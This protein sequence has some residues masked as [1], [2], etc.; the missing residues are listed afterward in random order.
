MK[1]FL[2][3]TA[4]LFSRGVLAQ[5]ADQWGS[6]PNRPLTLEDLIPPDGRRFSLVHDFKYIDLAGRKWEAPKGLRVDGASIPPPFWSVIGGPFEGLYR[7]ASVVHDAGCCAQMQPWRDVHHMFYNAM[8]CSGVGWVKAKTMFLAVWAFGPRWTRLNSSMPPECMKDEPST[9][10]RVSGSWRPPPDL[11]NDIWREIKRRVLSPAEIRAV[12]R[13]FFTR[14]PM[15]DSDAIGFVA[16]LKKTSDLTL[17]ER[18]AIALSVIQFELVSDEEVIELERWINEKNPPLEMVESTAE[19][20]RNTNV[21]ELRLFPDVR[22]LKQAV[23]DYRLGAPKGRNWPLL[24][25]LMW[26]LLVSIILVVRRIRSSRRP[27]PI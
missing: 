22:G 11:G 20:L 17:V 4:V 1:M 24:A 8:R 10:P 27:A 5:S 7:E 9:T 16:R 25:V 21:T 23:D 18:Q 15:T 14:G 3:V 6:Y 2:L 13:P 19:Q 12:A 26:S